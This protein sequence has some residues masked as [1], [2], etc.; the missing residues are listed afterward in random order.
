MDN[1]KVFLV[2]RINVSFLI[3]GGGG[4]GGENLI[5]PDLWFLRIFPI[6]LKED[7]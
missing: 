5:I 1:E 3:P 4:G 2:G 7:E 6:F